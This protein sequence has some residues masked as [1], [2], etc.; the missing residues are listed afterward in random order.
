VLCKWSSRPCPCLCCFD[1]GQN[2]VNL[3]QKQ[4]QAQRYSQVNWTDILLKIRALLYQPLRY[5]PNIVRLL[6]LGWGSSSETGSIYPTLKHENVLVFDN[7]YDTFRGQPYTAKLADFGGAV[8]DITEGA[9]HFLRKGTFPYDAPEAGQPLSEVGAKR[10][11]VY[12]FGMLVWRAFIDGT[13]IVTELGIRT[14][15]GASIQDQVREW[16]LHDNLLVKA[17]NSVASYSSA[18]DIPME[19]TDTILYSLTVTIRAE[20]AARDFVAAQARLRGMDE[21]LVEAYLPAAISTNQEVEDNCRNKTP[22][23][24][25]FN[26]DTLGY[27]LGKMGDD[28]DA[29]INLPNTRQN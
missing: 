28:H 15:R 24:H 2:E 29:Q 19:A 11:D 1:T 5:H 3:D 9:S 6:S 13:N 17:S 16:K 26:A 14:H 22:G 18:K 20:P 7:K 21:G 23:E 27:L 12:T 4:S 10:T 8:M 25:G